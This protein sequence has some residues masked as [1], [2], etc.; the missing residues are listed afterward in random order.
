MAISSGIKLRP[1]RNPM[2]PFIGLRLFEG[3]RIEMT[4]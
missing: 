3:A 2:A 1:I 4:L